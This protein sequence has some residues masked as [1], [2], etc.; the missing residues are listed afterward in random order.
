MS[1]TAGTIINAVRDLTP[2]PVYSGATPQPDTDGGLFRASTLYRWL[3]DGVRIMARALGSVITDWTAI[4]Q[5]TRQP[6]YA[7]PA[8]FQT[9]SDGFS[10]QW[11]LDII[12]LTEGDVI[13]PSTS[14]ATAQSLW[15][16][17]RRR[18]DHLEFG[19]WPVPNATD[20]TTTLVGALAASGVDPIPVAST[21]T[22]LSFGY[23][24]VDTEIIQYQQLTTGPAGI[25]TISRGAAGTTAAAHLTGATV[26]HL[27]LW[28][29]GTRSP[30]T[31]SAAASVVEVPLDVVSHLNTYLLA[32]C[33]RSEQEDQEARALF[34]EFDDAMRE[35]R[36]DPLRKENMGLIP[37]WGSPRIGPL[38]GG[39]GGLIV[40]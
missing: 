19:L 23:V 1:Y 7:L 9:I 17:L 12:T 14:Q 34:K 36:A 30:A 26:T 28:L 3:D 16:Y 33:R 10:N 13:W 25:G 27:G 31:I 32:C 38:Y 35:I 22:F 39:G 37:A 15:G 20:P 21:L 11:P 2:D 6:W 29:K 40:P 24:L 5:L 4:R 18:T 8:S